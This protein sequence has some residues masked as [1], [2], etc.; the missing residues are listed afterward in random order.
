MIDVDNVFNEN[1][2]NIFTDAS[3]IKQENGQTIA[4]AGYHSYINKNMVDYDI[5]HLQPATNN[6]GELTAVKMGVLSAIRLKQIYPNINAINLFS[7]S[8]LAV[9]SIREWIFN[10]VKK[11]RN[12]IMYNSSNSPVENQSFILAIIYTILNSN[13]EINFFHVR[14]HIDYKYESNINKFKKSFMQ[15]NNLSEQITDSLCIALVRNNANVDNMVYSS[16]RDRENYKIEKIH[17]P[18]PY[19]MVYYPFDINKY[20][21]LIKKKGCFI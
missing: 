14:S 9:Y 12:G 10:W 8:K 21:K 20:K 6:V 7:D 17:L 18:L 11:E 19:H 13:I 1:T 15:E 2:I 3:I 5:R 4:S 16:L